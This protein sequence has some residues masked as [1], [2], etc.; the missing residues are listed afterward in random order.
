MKFN[1]SLRHLKDFKDAQIQRH[2]VLE[3]ATTPEIFIKLKKEYEGTPTIII[4]QF[5]DGK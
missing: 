4:K 3:F 2:R 1:D 5:Y